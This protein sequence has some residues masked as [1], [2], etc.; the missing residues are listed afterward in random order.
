VSCAM[1]CC[2]TEPDLT[3]P[4]EGS[5]PCFASPHLMY[6]KTLTPSLCVCV[7]LLLPRCSCWTRAVEVL[8]PASPRLS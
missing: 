1:V 5:A 7:A 3:Q 6:I 8:Q 2:C 4:C